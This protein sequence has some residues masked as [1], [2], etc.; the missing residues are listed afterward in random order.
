M[1]GKPDSWLL[2]SGAKDNV[3]RIWH[4]TSGV[5]VAVGTGHLSSVTSVAFGNKHAPFL[6]SGSVDKLARVW[7]LEPLWAALAGGSVPSAPIELTTSSTV[8][9]HDKDINCVAVSPNNQLAATGSQDRSAKLW[10]LPSLAAPLLLKG[11]RR[12]IW[13]ICFSPVDAVRS[14]CCMPALTCRFRA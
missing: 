6:L 1:Q 4:V 3:V 8:A 2:A 5:C 9:A 13:D 7:N 14:S 11:H 12:G 10:R